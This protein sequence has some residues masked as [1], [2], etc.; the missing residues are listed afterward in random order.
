MTEEESKKLIKELND[1]AWV[2]I[3]IE[4]MLEEIDLE[5]YL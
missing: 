2:D 5:E 3:A 1:T 4:E